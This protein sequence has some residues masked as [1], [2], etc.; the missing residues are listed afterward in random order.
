MVNLHEPQGEFAVKLLRLLG[1]WEIVVILSV[2]LALSLA[3]IAHDAPSGSLYPQWCCNG[4]GKTGDCK[5]VT[6][7]SIAETKDGYEWQGY[8]FAPNRVMPSFDRQCHACI[9]DKIPMCL[10]ILPSS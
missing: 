10:F 3:A 6:C 7:D 9:H 5:E 4:D 8:R 1:F 2:L